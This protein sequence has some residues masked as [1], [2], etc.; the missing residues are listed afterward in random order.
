MRKLTALAR[1]LA[2]VGLALL[3][4][5]GALFQLVAGAPPERPAAAPPPGE[6]Q[7]VG[8]YVGMEPGIEQGGLALGF[9]Y[10]TNAPRNGASPALLHS[11]AIEMW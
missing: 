7:L 10:V 9:A 2:V 6:R 11:G 5:F 1:A 8:S 3:P 4:A